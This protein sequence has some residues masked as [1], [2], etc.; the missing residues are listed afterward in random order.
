MTSQEN[1]VAEL[2]KL[3]EASSANET[4]K[5]WNEVH[6]EYRTILSIFKSEYGPTVSGLSKSEDVFSQQADPVFRDLQLLLK[7]VRDK[8]SNLNDR[9][10]SLDQSRQSLIV[11]PLQQ[12]LPALI[13]NMRQF[14]GCSQTLS[15]CQDILGQAVFDLEKFLKPE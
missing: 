3:L 2:V 1:R 7:A 10:K 6:Y 15:D 11:L 4:A 9:V 14:V 12:K 5:T 13:V 8:L